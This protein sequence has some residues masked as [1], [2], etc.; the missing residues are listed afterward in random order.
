[1]RG[2]RG[3]HPSLSSPLSANPHAWG[4]ERQLDPCGRGEAAGFAPPSLS[5]IDQRV[6]RSAWSEATAATPTLSRGHCRMSLSLAASPS[7]RRPDGSGREIEEGRSGKES[8]GGEQW[9]R[10][11]KMS[12]GEIR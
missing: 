7:W 6:W 1:M 2:R 4:A 8:I 12:G 10:A 9:E 5:P 3:T 11:Q